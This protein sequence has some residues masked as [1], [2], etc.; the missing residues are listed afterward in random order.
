MSQSK[1]RKPKPDPKKLKDNFNVLLWVM[2]KDCGR[3][4][5]FKEFRAAL[6]IASDI[7]NKDDA[8]EI[9]N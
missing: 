4:K 8:N 6:E 2:W 1:K 9:P 7:L 5:K 3:K